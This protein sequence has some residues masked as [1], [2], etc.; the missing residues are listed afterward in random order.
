VGLVL[1]TIAAFAFVG[2]SAR[3]FGWREN[4]LIVFIAV[5]LV[6]VQFALSRYL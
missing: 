4:V 2:L 5:W 6:I 1:T 3:R